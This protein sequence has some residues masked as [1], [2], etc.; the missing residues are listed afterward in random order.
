MEQISRIPTLLKK[1]WAFLLLFLV[2][3]M[4]L[5]AQLTAFPNPFSEEAA[6]QFSLSVSDGV[7]LELYASTV[8][9]VVG[10]FEGRVEAG[11]EVA[12]PVSGEGLSNEFYIHRLVSRSGLPRSGKLILA[13]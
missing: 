12:V 6:M 13:K 9:R 1:S 7:S 2:T 8:Q 3:G 5:Q 11:Q 10:L 4:G